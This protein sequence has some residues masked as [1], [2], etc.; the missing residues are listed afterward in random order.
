M[1]NTI[2]TAYIQIEPTTQGIG[3]TISKALNGEAASAGAAAGGKLSSA[4]GSAAKVGSVAV[5]GLA[6]AI[7]GTSTALVNAASG[8]AQ[9]GD[10]IDKMSQKLGVSAG[11]YQ[12]WDA[13]LQ[14]SGTSMEGMQATFKTLSKAVQEGSSSQQAAFEQLGLSMDSLQGMSTDRYSQLLSENFRKWKKELKELHWLQV[15][16]EGV[17]QNLAH[18]LTH[19]QKTR[20]R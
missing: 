14:H 11:F 17:P 10:N 13:V 7:A 19:Q 1:A 20:R 3:G 12:E 16:W 18:F 6:T 4:L 5:A 2:G 8:T 15:F 9:Y